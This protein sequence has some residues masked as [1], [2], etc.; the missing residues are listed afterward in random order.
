MKR[1]V[2]FLLGAMLATGAMAQKNVRAA[3]KDS[4]ATFRILYKA[5]FL[6][7]E[8]S[9]FFHH[10]K[11]VDSLRFFDAD[12]DYRVWADIELTPESVPFD[13]PTTSGKLKPHKQYGILSFTLKGKPYRLSL[14]QNLNLLKDAKYKNELFLP[15]KD[16]T[17]SVTTYGGGRYIDLQ[18][19]DIV[20]DPATGKIRI[21]VDFNKCYNPYCAY[22]DGYNCPI[23]PSENYLTLPVKAGEKIYAGHHLD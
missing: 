21:L 9:P 14:Y 22:K 6:K 2:L 16:H 8:R 15:F 10:P 13:M 23:P 4:I 7:E 18:L 20:K 17:N 5:D 1:V 11:C 12:M 19:G 3:Y